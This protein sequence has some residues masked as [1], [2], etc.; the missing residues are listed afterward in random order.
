MVNHRTQALLSTLVVG[1]LLTGSA[2]AIVGGQEADAGEYEHLG[3]LSGNYILLGTSC[4]GSLIAP[5]V[6]LTAAHCVEGL[7]PSPLANSLLNPFVQT[8][9]VT[10]GSN[11]A[12]K[13]EEYR[14]TDVHIHPDYSTTNDIAVLILDRPASQQPIALAQP[15][16]E[17]LYGV[18]D[19]VTV[20][21]WGATSEG[22]S[23]SDILLEVDVPVVSDADCGAYYGTFDG[24]SEVCAGT[25]EGGKD[26]CQGDSGGPLMT[27]DEK[28]DLLL[29]GIVSRGEGCA[30]ADVPG[31]YTEVAAFGDFIGQFL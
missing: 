15:G 5:T 16:D 25:E 23:T 20:A 19:L 28:G 14:V 24:P 4:G 17:H 2:S 26:S 8:L 31:V 10:L 11:V 18:G 3:Y 29:I 12:G 6:F 21:G 1:L 30:R 7:A 13:G 22:G 9:Y 27:T